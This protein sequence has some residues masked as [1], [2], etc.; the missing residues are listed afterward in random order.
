MKISDIIS[1][2][3]EHSQSMLGRFP[4][5]EDNPTYLV[6]KTETEPVYGDHYFFEFRALNVIET[7]QASNMYPEF[8][9]Q[10]L[11]A[12]MLLKNILNRAARK[13]YGDHEDVNQNIMK[14]DLSIMDVM[15]EYAKIFHNKFNDVLNG[16]MVDCHVIRFSENIVNPGHLVIQQ[17]RY[18]GSLRVAPDTTMHYCIDQAGQIIYTALHPKYIFISKDNVFY[19][20]D[21]YEKLYINR[22]GE[23][24]NG[25][26]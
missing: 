18:I 3:R 4:R 1:A 15:E 14:F 21:L 8:K 19:M 6:Y 20:A 16:N 2:I 5:S 26:Q 25:N 13:L 10:Y 9:T 11:C 12:A 22:R 23:Y 24:G 17:A 7:A